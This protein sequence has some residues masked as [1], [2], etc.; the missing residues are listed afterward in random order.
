MVCRQCG[1]RIADK[2]LIC[3]RCGTAT[4]EARV[5]AP[6][7]Q[8]RPPVVSGRVLLAVMAGAL[9][10]A[11]VGQAEASEVARDAGAGVALVSG[12]AFAWR[13]VRPQ[14]R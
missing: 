3:F 7:R 11:G 2:A 12:A 5:P 1:T 14:S 10:V 4:T 9:V 13:L 6:S 8:A